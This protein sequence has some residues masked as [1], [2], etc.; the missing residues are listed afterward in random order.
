MRLHTCMFKRPVVQ[1]TVDKLP[2]YPRS[3]SNVGIPLSVNSFTSSLYSVYGPRSGRESL[4][5]IVSANATD[6]GKKVLPV[7]GYTISLCSNERNSLSSVSENLDRDANVPP[8]G[9]FPRVVPPKDPMILS[10][11][12]SDVD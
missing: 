1:T 12:P 6:P 10:R 11:R 8:L 2:P 7:S 9:E 4:T 3:V 5:S